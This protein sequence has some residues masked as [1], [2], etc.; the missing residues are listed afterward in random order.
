MAPTVLRDVARRAGRAM[1][2]PDVLESVARD[3]QSPAA[4]EISIVEMLSQAA[5]QREG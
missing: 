4:R 1:V 5:E 3:V 2:V